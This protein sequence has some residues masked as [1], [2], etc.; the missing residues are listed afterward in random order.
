MPVDFRCSTASRLDAEPM[1][2][3]APTDRAFLLVEYA[4]AWGRD[5]PSL[6]AEHV[7][8]PDGV[9]PQLIRRHRAAGSGGVRVFVAW[10]VADRFEVE[11]TRLAD[12][13]EL[14]TL[15]L[16]ALAE[17]RSPG[18]APYPGLLWLVCTNGR[19]DVCCAETGRPVAAALAGSW[20]EA[21]WETTHLGGHRFAGTLLALPTGITLG[22]LDP[23]T[24][25]LGCRA[26]AGGAHPVASSRGRAGLPGAV[27]AAELH[28]LSRLGAPV[29]LIGSRTEGDRTFATFDRGTVVVETTPGPPRRQSC[30]DLRTKPAPAHVVVGCEPAGCEPG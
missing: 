9:R 11:T 4:G 8:V 27:Q 28:L 12:L 14:A 26:V 13:S 23:A 30:A 6:L 19:R 10:L 25:V 29:T 3:T 1:A 15:D 18:L 20:P 22:R 7:R 5:A 2:G 24:A 21:T 16:G 17:G